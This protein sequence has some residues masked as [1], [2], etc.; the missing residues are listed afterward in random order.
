[1]RYFEMP[2]PGLLGFI[3][4]GIETWTMWQTAL[5]L[6]SP[7]VEAERHPHTHRGDRN[8]WTYGCL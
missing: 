7:F 5:L 3:A 4:F 8:V 6:L 2:V 1:V